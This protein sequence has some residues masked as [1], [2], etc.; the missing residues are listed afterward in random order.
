MTGELGTVILPK[1]DMSLSSSTLLSGT[2]Y[3]IVSNLATQQLCA[4]ANDDGEYIASVGE[5]SGC[6]P[7]TP[8]TGLRDY[9]KRILWFTEEPRGQ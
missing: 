5:V 1:P 4:L 7:L 6:V 8:N 9:N 2:Q 3:I